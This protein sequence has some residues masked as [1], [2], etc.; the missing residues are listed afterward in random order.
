ML[1]CGE[2]HVSVAFNFLP[3]SHPRSQCCWFVLVDVLF[4]GAWKAGIRR[5]A[6]RRFG[7]QA[8]ARGMSCFELFLALFQTRQNLMP[9]PKQ[10]MTIQGQ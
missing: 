6:F 8:R 1:A 10:K 9:A 2:A 5:A 4:G 7:S 3:V